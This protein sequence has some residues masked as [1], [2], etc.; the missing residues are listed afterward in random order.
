MTPVWFI[1]LDE[2]MRLFIA[3]SSFSVKWVN[4]IGNQNVV[5]ALPDPTN[6]LIIEGKDTSL[7]APHKIY[8][9]TTFITNTNGIFVMTRMTITA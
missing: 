3:I 4:L 2:E 1:W 7:I 6:V 5:A 8:W 9:A